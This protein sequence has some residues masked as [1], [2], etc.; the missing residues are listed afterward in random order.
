MWANEYTSR[1]GPKNVIVSIHHVPKH[2][3]MLDDDL[4]RDCG[5]EGVRKQTAGISDD[6]NDININVTDGSS[7][8]HNNSKLVR[9]AKGIGTTLN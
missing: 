3:G 1:K 4:C 2:Y 8:T 6:H 7:L 9:S 5:K